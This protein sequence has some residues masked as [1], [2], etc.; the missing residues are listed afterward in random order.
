MRRS[1]A[2]G[3]SSRALLSRSRV[4]GAVCAL[5]PLTRPLPSPDPDS[6]FPSRGGNFVLLLPLSETAMGGV[7]D[8]RSSSASPRPSTTL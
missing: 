2:R 5:L 6:M 1:R 4:V 3:F 7:V 8:H